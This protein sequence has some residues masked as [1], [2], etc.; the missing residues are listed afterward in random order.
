MLQKAGSAELNQGNPLFKTESLMIG[1]R[2]FIGRF[3]LK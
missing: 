2:G 1:E 3:G